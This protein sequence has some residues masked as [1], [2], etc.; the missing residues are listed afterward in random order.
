MQTLPW[1]VHEGEDPFER[2]ARLTGPDAALVVDGG[3]NKGRTVDR[4]LA[5]Y[6]RAA[7]YA[8]EPLP[9]LARKLAKR[10]AAEPRVAVRPVALGSAPAVL[11]LNVLESATC[12]SLLPPSGILEKHADKPMG[13]AQAV[14]VA[15]ARLDAELAT[16]PDV[17][18]LDLQGFELEALKGL[19]ELIAGVKAVLCEVSFIPMYQGQPLGPEVIAWMEGKGFAV[20][21]LYAPWPGRDGA[22]V[23]A[24]ALFT[25]S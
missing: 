23:A 20:E 7:V 25:R 22:I 16:A 13:L 19:G 12:S 17:V 21:G 11:T 14:D 9:R 1:I 10:F 18:K 5:L 4:L 2:M 15:V 3:A 6:P 8:Y 24:D